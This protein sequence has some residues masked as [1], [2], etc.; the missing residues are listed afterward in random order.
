MRRAIA[1]LG[2]TMPE[3]LPTAENTKY[4]ESTEKYREEA[5]RCAKSETQEGRRKRVV[6]SLVSFQPYILL[7]FSP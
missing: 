7:M 4:L 1:E 5:A 2:G 6:P 3:D